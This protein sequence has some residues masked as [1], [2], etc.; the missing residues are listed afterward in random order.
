MRLADIYKTRFAE[1]VKLTREVESR[2]L[3]SAVHRHL[4]GAVPV[5]PLRAPAP[6]GRRVRRGSSAACAAHRPRRQ[7]VLRSDRLLRRQRLRLR[8]L[9]VVHRPRHRARARARPGARPLPPGRRRQRQTA[10][11]DLRPRRGLV[12]HVGHRGGHAG[13]AP[14]ALP[15]AALAPGPLLRRLPRLVGRRAARASATRRPRTRPTRSRRWT[16]TRC[17]CCAT[18]QRHRLRAGQPAAGAAPERQ[19]AQRLDPARQRPYRA[20]RPPGLRRLA[21]EAARRSA[22][23]AAS[24]SSSTR[25]SWA[26]ASARAARRSTSA[27]RPTWSPTARRWAAGCR[28]ACSAAA[29]TS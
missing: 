20:L 18:A 22:A 17:A 16:T 27:S 19:R 5:Q 26:S 15:H 8:L 6:G 24:C 13:G 14:G 29:R 12:P 4:P 1:T 25:S 23:S 3:R 10:A 7:P 21:Q 28:S 9:Q 11:R 2:D